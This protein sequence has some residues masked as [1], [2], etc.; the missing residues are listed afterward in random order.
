M[1]LI[2]CVVRL[3]SDFW[4]LLDDVRRGVASS[5]DFSDDLGVERLDLSDESAV[6]LAADAEDL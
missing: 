6:E 1:C 4:R 3:C 5:L 2:S